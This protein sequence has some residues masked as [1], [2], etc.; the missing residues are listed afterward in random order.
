MMIDAHNSQVDDFKRFKL[1]TVTVVDPNGGM[2]RR[3]SLYANTLESLTERTIDSE[4]G[5][6]LHIT[7]GDGTDPIP[8][9]NYLADFT[10]NASQ[11][12]EFGSNLK[13][14]TKTVKGSD[15]ATAIIP[16]GE[17][18][19]D[20]V[21]DTENLPLTIADINDGVDYVY[22]PEG[23][24]LY[25]WIFKT[26]EYEGVTVAET[27]KFN[28][29]KSLSEI[30]NQNITIELNAVD[31][32][33]LDRSIES[34]N[35]GDYIRVIS[36]PHNFDSTLLCQKMTLDLLKPENDSLTLGRTYSTF[37]EKSSEM[38][39]S[40]SSISTIRSSV[41]KINSNVVKLNS[42]VANMQNNTTQL[43]ERIAYKEY[44]FYNITYA[45]GAIGQIP[46]LT[47]DIPISVCVSNVTDASSYVPFVFFENAYPNTVILNL[48][49][50][51]TAAVN[52]HTVTVRVTYHKSTE[53]K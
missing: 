26:I 13:K 51:N 16:L 41:N 25:G 47:H 2:S 43:S 39:S 24:A 44:T 53:E 33:L 14:Y 28:A 15:I 45:P 18:V 29:E 42:T 35:L 9:I 1:G 50:T 38:S 36:E 30:I 4:L 17:K 32:H 52:G 3:S 48:Y 21:E 31:L 5:G 34:F 12:V 20:G 40:V 22:S 19:D 6:Y 23:V 8:T 49:R 37:T 11:V 7:H 10:N 46:R 27:L